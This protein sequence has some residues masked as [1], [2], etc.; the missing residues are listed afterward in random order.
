[1]EFLYFTIATSLFS[2]E[3]L[4]LREHFMSKM[5]S[6]YR[7]PLYLFWFLPFYCLV[8]LYW[9]AP[10]LLGSKMSYGTRKGDIYSLAIII[11]EI[12]S[13]NPPYH[14]IIQWSPKGSCQFCFNKFTAITIR[15][16]HLHFFLSS[17]F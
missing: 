12:G 2:I 9:T 4:N 5:P 8:D 10:E 1:M 6:A 17:T 3:C 15:Y 11:S 16:T 14:D 13:R 7:L